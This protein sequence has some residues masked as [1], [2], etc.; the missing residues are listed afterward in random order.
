MCFIDVHAWAADLFIL[1]LVCVCARVCVC[2]C[3]CVCVPVSVCVCVCVRVR[4]CGGR[5]DKGAANLLYEGYF[6]AN[7]SDVVVVTVQYRLGALGFLITET[8]K[9][10]RRRVREIETACACVCE[11]ASN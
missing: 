4:V 3:A 10:V 2:L 7:R 11:C 1:F 8:L 6:Q 5:Q 9:C